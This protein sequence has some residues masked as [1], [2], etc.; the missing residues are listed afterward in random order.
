MWRGKSVARRFV[1]PEGFV[2]LVGRTAVEND[3]LTF[4]LGAPQDFWLHVASESGSHV[5][6]R[7]PDRLERLP[8]AT[9]RL[10]AALAAGYSKAHAAGRATVHVA[11]CADVSKPRGAPPGLVHLKHFKT[12]H[13]PPQRGAA[14]NENTTGGRGAG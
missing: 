10:A 7:N 3:I 6:V 14:A 4:E 13:V 8:R 12:L 2:I 5:V 1:S 11:T 9:L